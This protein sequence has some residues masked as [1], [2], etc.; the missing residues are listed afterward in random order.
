MKKISPNSLEMLAFKRPYQNV[1]S[2]HPDYPYITKGEK[3][4]SI[5]A[6]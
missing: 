6:K 2:D 5:C 3:K 1:L 4:K